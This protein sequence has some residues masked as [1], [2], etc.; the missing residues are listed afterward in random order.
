MF[1]WVLLAGC[2]A[3]VRLTIAESKSVLKTPEKR[4][5]ISLLEEN[6]YKV[7][8]NVWLPSHGFHD[9]RLIFQ[10]NLLENMKSSGLKLPGID[11]K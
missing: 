10:E 8:I 9:A 5:G 11:P 6:G 3:P 7:M 4:V 2:G 1:T